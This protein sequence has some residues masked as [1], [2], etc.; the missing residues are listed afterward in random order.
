MPVVDRHAGLADQPVA[1]A[2]PKVERVA[3]RQGLDSSVPN[4]AT[5]CFEATSSASSR[6]A[7]S[8]MVKP[9]I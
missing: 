2:V 6:T 7:Q 1:E 3:N 5:G 8:R 9:L 4:R